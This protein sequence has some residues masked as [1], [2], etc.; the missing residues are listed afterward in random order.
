MKNLLYI[1][2][3][4]G[5]LLFGSC[6]KDID[7]P[8]LPQPESVPLVDGVAL[9]ASQLFGVWKAVTSYGSNNTNYFEQAYRIEF[10]SVDDKEA[11]VSHWYT[12]GESETRDSVYQ[13]VYTYTFDGTTV[14]LT[15]KSAR[16]SLSSMKAIH[17]GNNNMILYI[18]N[19]NHTDNVCTLKRTGDPEPSIT[20]VDRT[21]PAIGE[22]VTITGRNLQFVDHIFLPTTDGEI[23]V[24]DITPGSKQISFVVPN[25]TYRAGSIR[26]QSTT[27]HV[28]CYSPA[29]MFC[30]ECIYLH[31][32]DRKGTSEPYKGTE[33]EYTIKKG[34]TTTPLSNAFN[35]E[36]DNLPTGHSLMTS[37]VGVAHPDYL[38]SFFGQTPKAWSL[39]A[40]TNPSSGYLRFSS[41]DRFQYVLDNCD[42]MLTSRTRCKDVAIQMDI[43]VYSNGRPEWTTGYLSYRLNKDQNSLTSSMVANVAIWDI[44]A[45]TSFADGW[46][47]LT[48][49]LTTFGEIR[50]DAS[51]TLGSLIATLKGSNLFTIVIPVNYPLDA[52]HP[53][54]ALDS[55]QF[56]I[57]NM[58]LVPYATIPNKNE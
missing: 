33:F 45:P 14:E 1:I 24:T 10:M 25:A 36:S 3:V 9:D 28:S 56:N 19:G 15:P 38:L 50:K 35:L 58:R 46:R 7:A 37:A 39:D 4:A 51:M 23:E 8:V 31:D 48:I 53:A 5:G 21:L 12:N 22:T 6:S 2:G 55:F 30:E 42:G 57:A 17:T 18:T 49:P 47:T 54:Q 43:Y 16:S 34:G 27:A 40:N 32:F 26:C 29:Y 52:A 11:L 20:S 44:D 13:A 41:G